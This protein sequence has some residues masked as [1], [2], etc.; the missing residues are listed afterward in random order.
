MVVHA[1]STRTSSNVID[2]LAA[3]ISSNFKKTQLA[4]EI[5]TTSGETKASAVLDTEKNIDLNL[6]AAS[7]VVDDVLVLA[8]AFSNPNYAENVPPPS[9]EE[10]KSQRIIKPSLAVV[11]DS[12]KEKTDSFAKKDA[13][14]FWYFGK[15]VSITAK[16]DKVTSKGVLM[17]D[18]F[19]TAATASK[20]DLKLSK[21]SGKGRSTPFSAARP[22][23][24]STQSAKY[25]IRS[26]RQNSN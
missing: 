24:R 3:E 2:K 19:N 16:I 18:S 20:N 17:L 8:G 5:K 23:L 10:G 9:P 4:L 12:K 6:K 15:D 26:N 25:R 11:E 1:L 7:I 13:K 22:R 14:A 21:F